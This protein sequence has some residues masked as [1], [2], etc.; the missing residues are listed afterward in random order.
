M[1]KIFERLI[2]IV[3]RALMKKVD[4]AL[5]QYHKLEDVLL[6]VQCFMNNDLFVNL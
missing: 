1:G 5:L 3:K 4:R 6:D 2:G